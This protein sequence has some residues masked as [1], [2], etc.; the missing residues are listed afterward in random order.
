MNIE[1][2][3]ENVEQW[4]EDRMILMHSKPMPQLMK[5]MSELGELAD[6]TLKNDREEI[7]DGIGDVLVTLII[8]SALQFVTLETALQAAYDQIKDRKGFLT[9]EGIFVR[10]Q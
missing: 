8:Y 1:E 6:A 3:I 10:Q 5:T 2:L 7:I 4:A 9:P